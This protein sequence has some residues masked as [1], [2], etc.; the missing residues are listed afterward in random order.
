MLF[1]LKIVALIIRYFNVISCVES[2]ERSD[3]MVGGGAWYESEIVE[4]NKSIPNIYYRYICT[5]II[6]TPYCKRIPDHIFVKESKNYRDIY[7]PYNLLCNDTVIY[8]PIIY[9]F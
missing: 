6:S 9:L 2:T 3:A 1:D 7:Y 4:G 5:I 8:I